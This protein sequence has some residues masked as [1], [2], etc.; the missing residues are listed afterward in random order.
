L[1]VVEVGGNGDDGLRH[2][3]AEITLGRFLHLLQC[4]GGHL[5]RRQLLALAALHPRI[6]VVGFDD[7]VGHHADV[8]LGHRIFELAP[9]QALD[10]EVGVFRVRDR[11]AL[12]GLS[13]QPLTVLGEGNDRGGGSSTFRVLKNL[14]LSAFHDGDARVR[15]AKV[16]ADNF[17]H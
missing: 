13:D 8:L 7:L 9:D 10:G 17:S 15:R 3:L 14:R 12:G 11:L 2:L 5:A 16:D 1:R 4:V 6:A